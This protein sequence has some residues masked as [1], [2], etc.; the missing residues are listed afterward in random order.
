MKATERRDILL[1]IIDLCESVSKKGLNPFDVRVG[2]LFDK[3]RELLPLLRRHEEL[4]LDLQAVVGLAEVIRQQG[5]WIKH[6]SSLLYLDP[7]LV[8]LKIHALSTEELAQIFVRSW[9]P[10][11][12]LECLTPLGLKEGL[13][14]WKFLP[15]LQERLRELPKMEVQPGRI[16]LKELEEMG[17][18][19]ECFDEMLDSL[20][21]ELR[22]RG[23]VDYW[24][25]IKGKNFSERVKRAYLLSF[26]I[27]Y[28]LAKIY[29]D[30]I[31][32]RIEVEA[33]DEPQRKR[34]IQS[35]VISI[36]K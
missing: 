6:R 32:E 4:A 13:E 23:R 3:L 18:I 34:E 9:H 29:L 8:M 36:T 12:E 14:Y 22:K 17:F 25:F 28:G 27:T 30:P 19:H 33:V 24:K 2:E 7:L 21:L 16:G 10:I 15:S 26:L 20:W 5:E 31:E 1:R 35:M 11:L